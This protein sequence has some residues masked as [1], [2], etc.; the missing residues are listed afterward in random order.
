MAKISAETSGTSWSACYHPHPDAVDA[1][2]R[3]CS[4]RCGSFP[5]ARCPSV[6]NVIVDGAATQST[7]L[8]LSH[9]PKS[10]T[11]PELKGDTSTE[12]VFN[13]VDAPRFH[14]HADAVSNNHFDEDGLIGIFTLVAPSMAVRHGRCCSTRPRPVI[15]GSLPTVTPHESRSRSLLTP[16]RRPRR[17]PAASSTCRIQTWR[18]DCTSN[19]SSCCHG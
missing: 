15:S 2:A 4:S 14:V 16:M 5:I 3:L 17:S 11:P 13:Y 8:T 10:G 18:A 19:C 6:Q 7:I 1:R 9:W 12:I